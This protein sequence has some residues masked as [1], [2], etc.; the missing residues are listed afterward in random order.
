VPALFSRSLFPELMAL[1]GHEGARRV[2][3][4][5]SDETFGVHFPEG[6]FDLDTPADYAR[7]SAML[8]L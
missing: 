1:D 4:A 2:I 5:R 7:L 8:S 3:Q 6:V